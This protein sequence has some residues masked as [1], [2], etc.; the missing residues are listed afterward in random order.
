MGIGKKGTHRRR[1]AVRASK[2]VAQGFRPP[3]ATQSAAARLGKKERA[4]ILRYARALKVLGVAPG[5]LLWDEL[6]AELIVQRA[7]A[8]VSLLLPMFLE[9]MVAHVAGDQSYDALDAPSV[10]RVL[11]IARAYRKS[12]GYRLPAEL[13]RDVVDLEKCADAFQ[14]RPRPGA[15]KK[16]LAQLALD[17]FHDS[18]YVRIQSDF[19]Q[20]TGTPKPKSDA[21]IALADPA[22]GNGFEEAITKAVTRQVEAFKRDAG[23]RTA[24]SPS[25]RCAL[26]LYEFVTQV[27]ARDGLFER[28]RQYVQRLQRAL[29][30]LKERE[31]GFKPKKRM[32]GKKT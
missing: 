7:P 16:P 4:E 12:F 6:R 18:V 9:R 28:A 15:V 25:D 13:A 19:A 30:L 8:H 14:L 11:K 5:H 17:H 21:G 26:A 27:P 1:R 31:T 23:Q 3:K 29:R 20:R 32:S 24:L 22:G 10:R 2:K